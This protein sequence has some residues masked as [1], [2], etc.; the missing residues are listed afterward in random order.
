MTGVRGRAAARI[1]VCGSGDGIGANLEDDNAFAVL[2][3]LLECSLR[4]TDHLLAWA[5]RGEIDPCL[6]VADLRFL[7][8]EEQDVATR[9]RGRVD[10]IDCDRVIK[11]P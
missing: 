6:A 5:E 8:N 7:V 11:G 9:P 4:H 3:S 10:R 2:P 1:A